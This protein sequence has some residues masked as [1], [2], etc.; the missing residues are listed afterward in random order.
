[1]ENNCDERYFNEHIG[2]KYSL[3]SPS[4]ILFEVI[5]YECENGWMFVV[6]VSTRYNVIYETSWVEKYDSDKEMLE[7]YR[8]IHEI[9]RK[10]Y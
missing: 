5:N 3:K 9:I 2:E 6:Q 1:M 10:Y 4:G 7:S 8:R